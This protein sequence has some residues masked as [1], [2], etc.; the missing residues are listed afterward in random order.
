[1]ITSHRAKTVLEGYPDVYQIRLLS[2]S[3]NISFGIIIYIFHR[4]NWGKLR[5]WSENILSIW[6]VLKKTTT[7]LSGCSSFFE[8]NWG[9]WVKRR[10]MGT[11]L[12]FCSRHVAPSRDSQPVTRPVSQRCCW[13]VELCVC[14][15]FVRTDDGGHAVWLHHDLQAAQWT[16]SPAASKEGLW[17]GRADQV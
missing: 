1:M 17:A 12:P 10:M 4:A 16:V 7:H 11:S 2:P 3:W 13:C 9:C 6:A 8:L 14:R 5:A 15:V